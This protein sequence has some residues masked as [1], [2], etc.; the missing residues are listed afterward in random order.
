[1]LLCVNVFIFIFSISYKNTLIGF[2]THLSLV[3]S[4]SILIFIISAKTLFASK[5]TFEVLSSNEFWE[6]P[7][8]P[9]HKGFL[10]FFEAEPHYVPQLALNSQY[11]CPSLLS[12]D[13]FLATVLIAPRRLPGTGSIFHK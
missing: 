13:I 9:Q 4:L 10:S 12:T 8:N 7:F 2:R 3:R 11:S 5:V 1:L 6:S